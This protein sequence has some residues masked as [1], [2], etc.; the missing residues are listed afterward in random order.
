MGDRDIKKKRNLQ[1]QAKIRP[2]TIL[3]ASLRNRL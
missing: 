2:I 1:G 3:S